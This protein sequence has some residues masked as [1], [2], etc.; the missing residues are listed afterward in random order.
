VFRLTTPTL[1]ETQVGTIWKTPKGKMCFTTE[2]K[3]WDAYYEATRTL[4]DAAKAA[5][6]DLH[7]EVRD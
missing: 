3:V 5:G 7:L 2:E 6:K 4:T 1:W